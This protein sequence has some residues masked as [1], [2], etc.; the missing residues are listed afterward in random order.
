MILRQPSQPKWNTHKNDG[1]ILKYW[2]TNHFSLFLKIWIIRRRRSVKPY[3]TLLKAFDASWG[4][5]EGMEVLIS[6]DWRLQRVYVGAQNRLKFV[7]FKYSPH[8]SL[9]RSIDCGSTFR[10]S[11][12]NDFF[13]FHC[14]YLGLLTFEIFFWIS[15]PS[16][17][18]LSR[19]DKLIP[20]VSQAS[21]LP[22]G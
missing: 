21:L 5:L 3:I 14:E 1:R 17:K 9:E 7:R 22:C 6:K 20:L 10:S 18:T 12:M 4:Q 11:S 15:I 8:W 19:S 16:C 13:I 2:N